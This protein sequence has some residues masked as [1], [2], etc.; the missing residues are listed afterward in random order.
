M[1]YPHRPLR[2]K[3]GQGCGVIFV[4][5]DVN[6]VHAGV[7]ERLLFTGRQLAHALPERLLPGAG[8]RPVCLPGRRA[9]NQA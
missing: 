4:G 7:E 8:C 1:P 2:E 5:G 9:A 3:L 6:A